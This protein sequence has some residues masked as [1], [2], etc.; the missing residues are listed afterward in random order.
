MIQSHERKKNIFIMLDMG[1]CN[2][3][4]ELQKFFVVIAKPCVC[5]CGFLGLLIIIRKILELRI[6]SEI[7]GCYLASGLRV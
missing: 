4:Q 3:L 7:F 5:L 2:L 1:W 6:I